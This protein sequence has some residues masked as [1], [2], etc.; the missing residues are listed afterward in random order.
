MK[1]KLMLSI[2]ICLT[3]L[4][5]VF[6]QNSS[7]YVDVEID[8]EGDVLFNADLDSEGENYVYING[9]IANPTYEITQIS[10]S[11]TN[12]HGVFKTISNLF[13]YYFGES[14]SRPDDRYLEKSLQYLNNFRQSIIQEVYYTQVR[15]LQLEL[16]SQRKINNKLSS[17]INIIKQELGLGVNKFG[18]ECYGY[19]KVLLE[20]NTGIKSVS[21]QEG[22][23]TQVWVKQDSQAIMVRNIQND[24]LNETNSTINESIICFDDNCTTESF[25][26]KINFSMTTNEIEGSIKTN[27]TK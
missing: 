5:L 12:T 19:V 14:T 21:C 27:I 26:N 9:E 1:Y 24:L 7:T 10:K 25:G 6:A 8:S 17:E 13:E 20:E 3:A 11:S 2:L 16:L 15:D 23:E 4:P 18:L 22:N